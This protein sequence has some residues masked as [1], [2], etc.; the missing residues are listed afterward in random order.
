MTKINSIEVHFNQRKWYV[1]SISV[2]HLKVYFTIFNFFR[3]ADVWNSYSLM[4][5]CPMDSP[6]VNEDSKTKKKKTIK[7]R[8]KFHCWYDLRIFKQQQRPW[9]GE[10]KEYEPDELEPSNCDPDD[11]LQ[12]WAQSSRKWS[13]L[14]SMAKGILTI[15]TRS[16]SSERAFS[17]GKDVFG[18]SRMSLCPETIEALIYLRPWSKAGLLEDVNEV[19]FI[20]EMEN[21]NVDESKV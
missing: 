6:N 15:P 1:Y 19:A 11:I 3:I 7:V 2:F 5:Y 13:R 8:R 10:L 12:Y 14:S 20:R 17:G 16:A 21:A 18:L 9:K 4:P